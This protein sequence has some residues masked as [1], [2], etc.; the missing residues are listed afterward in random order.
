M[1]DHIIKRQERDRVDF[2]D[3]R[4]LKK[5]RIFKHHTETNSNQIY[6]QAQQKKLDVMRNWEANEMEIDHY[7]KNM[8]TMT[9]SN[10]YYR[11]YNPTALKL[12]KP[13]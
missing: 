8:S 12:L 9:I 11:H 6:K 1:A 13:T 5:P 4:L 3:Q 10:M 7:V 2:L